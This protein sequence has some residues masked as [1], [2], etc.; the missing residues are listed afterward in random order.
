MNLSLFSLASVV[1]LGSPGPAIAALIAVGKERGFFQGLRFYAGLQLGLA[2]AAGA[3]AAGLFSAFAA[4][5]GATK[6][7]MFIA[8]AYLLYLS[9]KI[10]FAPV[11]ASEAEAGSSFASTVGGGML[12]G[13]TNPKAYIAFASLMASYA[14]ARLDTVADMSIKWII[15]VVVMI[16]ADLAWLWAGVVLGRA[17]L[18]PTTERTIN[19]LM[20]CTILATA[21]MAI[22]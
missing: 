13:V 8:T 19:A 14:I 15:C 2:T 16:V 18:K 3:S 1:L 20:G 4:I 22:L 21:L 9:Y 7:M 11:G 12:L 10:A 6:T 5:P 17:D